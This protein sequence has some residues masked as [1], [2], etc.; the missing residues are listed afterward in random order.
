M[1]TATK[2]EGRAIPWNKGKLLGQK[3]PLKLRKSGPSGFDCNWIIEPGNSLSSTSP[4]IASYAGAI[5]LDFVS[6][7]WSKAIMSPPA[8]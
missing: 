6:T 3:P 4:S 7:T 1:D 2:T 5:W 8:R